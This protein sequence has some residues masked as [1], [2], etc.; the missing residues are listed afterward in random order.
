MGDDPFITPILKTAQN[1]ILTGLQAQQPT[2]QLVTLVDEAALSISTGIL[3]SAFTDK[4]NPYNSHSRFINRLADCAY[5]L[6]QGDTKTFAPLAATEVMKLAQFDE[7]DVPLLANSGFIRAFGQRCLT[8]HLLRM[9]QHPK[10]F[11]VIAPQQLEALISNILAL[12]EDEFSLNHLDENDSA[13]KE[14]E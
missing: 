10:Q 6:N 11:D 14:G 12:W 2:Q 9:Q 13:T 8:E 4:E 5:L 3:S 1:E 7:E